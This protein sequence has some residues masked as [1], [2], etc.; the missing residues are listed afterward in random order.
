MQPQPP[1]AERP[2][3]TRARVGL[4]LG[5]ALFFVVLLLPPPGGMP[6]PAW[7]TAAV[8][9]LMAT[10]W[11]SE[12]V[13][14]PA[15]ALLP[16]ALFPV[17]G[18]MPIGE[19]S[20]PFAN[21]VIYLFLGGFLLALA[22]EKCGLH[23]RIALRVIAVV[24]TRPANLIGGF[25]VATALL[26][27]WVSNTAAVIMMLPVAHS[28]IRLMRG[29]G[30]GGKRDDAN[31]AIA[32]L[33]GVAYAASIGGIGTLI[34]TPPNALLAGFM[35]E[36][37]GVR[38]G[39]AQWM[40]FGVPIVVVGVPLAWVLLTR[41]VFPVGRDAVVGSAELIDDERRALGR[42]TSAETR[43]A[44]VGAAMALAWMTQPLLERVV[45]GLSDTGIAIGGAL[46]LFLMPVD[47][48]RG[49]FA[50]HWKE[51][52]RLPWAV[53]VLFGG[54]L[55]LAAAIQG[56]GLSAWIGEQMQGLQALPLV[57]VTLLVVTVIVFLTELTS[58]TATAAAFL[59][60]VAATAVALGA[61]PLVLAIPAAV[62]ASCAFMLPVATPPN[63]IVYGT[64][65][66]TIPQM[67]RAGFWLNLIM[68]TLLTIAV[69]TVGRVVIPG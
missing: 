14:I 31:F 22:V 58:N 59:P 28:V 39:F 29:L 33:L 42:R 52:E 19:A 63:A 5:V 18:I 53:L 62:G 20:A 56:T 44:M 47:W 23:R 35:S 30:G 27:M 25:M 8:A 43:V 61:D 67:V 17:L 4:F 2:S 38:I 64:G 9:V 11:V 40:L 57:A 3:L 60:V 69:F 13:P 10:W 7:R 46:L 55:S 15:T 49:Q 34:G 66:V 24:G 21:P 16:L 65:D 26:S 50:L 6:L 12:A 37:Y 51:A 54:G 32:I 48:R 36:V 68:I 41:L 1:G 45:P